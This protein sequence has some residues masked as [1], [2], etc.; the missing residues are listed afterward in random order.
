MHGLWTLVGCG[1]A[2]PDVSPVTPEAPR[3]SFRA[4]GVRAAGNMGKVQDDVRKHVAS[5]AADS[6]PDVRL[7][8]AIAARKLEGLETLTVLL[9]VLSSSQ[10]PLIQHVVWQNLHPMLDEP[11][12]VARLVESSKSHDSLR[13]P[14]LATLMPRILDRVIAA[15]STDAD[16][17][18]HLIT[19]ALE[20]LGDEATHRACL[21]ALTEQVRQG[22]LKGDRLNGVREQ[23]TPWPTRSS[24]KSPRPSAEITPSWPPLGATPTH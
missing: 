19:M 24:V 23:L 10:D 12:T 3:A 5:M 18:A 11:A 6:S 9:E 17:M 7:Q 22:R 16:T 20:Q 1:L 21:D 4:W 14:R 13:S 8:V 2:R 15:G